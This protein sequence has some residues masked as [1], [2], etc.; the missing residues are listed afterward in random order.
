MENYNFI[1]DRQLGIPLRI[2][3]DE[4]S[5]VILDFEEWGE[6]EGKLKNEAIGKTLQE[7]NETTLERLRTP[8]P[9][10]V[11]GRRIT[12]GKLYYS[13]KPK[14]VDSESLFLL[15]KLLYKNTLKNL[16]DERLT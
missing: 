2:L 7:F 3:V 8:I 6:F 5:G 14:W 13:I 4:K 11:N 9:Y 10:E 15:G 16:Q 1:I 12:P